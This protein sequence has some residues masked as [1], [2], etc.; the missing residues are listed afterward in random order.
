MIILFG[1]ILKWII[2]SIVSN[3][4]IKREKIKINVKSSFISAFLSIKGWNEES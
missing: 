1:V 2:F 4:R 3:F